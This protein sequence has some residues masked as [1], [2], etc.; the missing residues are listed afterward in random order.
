MDCKTNVP[1]TPWQ[2]IRVKRASKAPAAPA[3]AT[4]AATAPVVTPPPAT[5]EP[6]KSPEMLGQSTYN[7][8]CGRCHGLKPVGDYTADRWVGIMESMAPKARLDDTE[9]Q[10]VLAYVKANAKK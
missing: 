6:A 2:R 1:S 3:T 4:V 5:A 7:G 10:N 8:K 9:K